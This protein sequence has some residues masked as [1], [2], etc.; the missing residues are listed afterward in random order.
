DTGIGMTPDQLAR[1]F[2]AFSQADASTTRKFGGTG[3]GLAIS[4]QLV[5]MMG[6]S[7]WVESELGRGSTFTFLA[8]F[9]KHT[10]DGQA[11]AGSDGK[12]SLAGCRTLIVD[13][14]DG[15]SATAREYLDLLG[16]RA[17]TCRRSEALGRLRE[18]THGRDPFRLV[19]VDLSPPEPE[20]FALSR[21]IATDPAITPNVRVC[22][23]ESPLRGENRLKEFGFAAAMQKPVTPALLQETLVAALTAAG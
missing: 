14:R 5:E 4:K 2:Q 23:T 3:L 19:L 20:I 1:M 17:E 7:I 16:C 10:L 15:F 11:R 21:A 6:G 22:C 12:A 18:A 8:P 9:G 13:D